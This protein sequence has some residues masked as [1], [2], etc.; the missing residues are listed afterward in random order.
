DPDLDRA[1][2]FGCVA[3]LSVFGHGSVHSFLLSW[4]GGRTLADG[5]LSRGPCTDLGNVRQGPDHLI[6]APRRSVTHRE[7][8]RTPTADL[9]RTQLF[10][11]SSPWITSTVIG[12]SPI[13]KR[14]IPGIRAT[15]QRAWGGR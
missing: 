13:S 7:T 5:S 8:A 2:R 14:G 6:G 1:G 15:S 4:P 9:N 3:V 11:S 12:C 10:D